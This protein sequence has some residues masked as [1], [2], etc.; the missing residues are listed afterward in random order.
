MKFKIYSVR[1]LVSGSH[2]GLGFAET[3]GAFVR[4]SL[5]RFLQI[6]PRDELAYYHVGYFDNTDG[7]IE[8]C[9]ATKC[10]I[11]AYKFPEAQ[12]RPID[13]ESANKIAAALAQH[14]NV[15]KADN[16]AVNNG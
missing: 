15:S 6:R 10:D 14:M 2:I 9:Q 4:D 8:A 5:V 1:D 16:K 7:S 3:D 13:D 11:D 12:S